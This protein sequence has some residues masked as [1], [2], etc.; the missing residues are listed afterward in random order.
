MNM[1]SLSIKFK[2][3]F[4][5][6]VIKIIPLLFLSYIAY[7][8]VLKLEEYFSSSTKELFIENKEIIANTA[9]KAVGDSIKMLDKKSQIS[10]EKLS[11]ELSNN[12]ANFLYE[13]DKD[14]LFLSTLNL[15]QNVLQNFYNSK[16]RDIIVHGNYFYD[17]ET[18]TWKNRNILD[19]ANRDMIQASL[20][21]NEKEFNF[22][23]PVQ[24]KKQSIPIY[25]EVVYFDLN[26]EE[27]FKV[28]SIDNSLKNISIKK[29]T[30]INSENYFSELA[31]LKKGDIY[32]SDVIGEYVGSKVIGPFTKEKTQKIGIEFEPEKY[33]Y[34]G[35]ENPVGKEFEAIVRFITPYYENNQKVGY[36]SLALDHKHI[37][38][39]TD[40]FDPTGKDS[41]QDISDASSGNYA[42]MWDYEGKN[43]SHAR[44][45]FI[46]GYDKNTGQLAKPWLSEDVSKDFKLSN[47]DINTFL[48]AYPTFKEQNIEKK[49]DLSQIKEGLLGLDCRYLNSA[50]QCQGWMQITENGGYGSFMILWSGVSK[51][52]TGATIPYYT[53]KYNN[54]KRGFGFVT[55][56][57]NVDEFHAA[58]N[59]TKENIDKLLL[60][61]TQTMSESLDKNKNQIDKF[62]FS[63]LNELSI[64]TLVMVVLIV[65]IALLM[66]NYISKKIKNLLLGTENFTKNNLDYRIKVS[67]ND[68]VGRLEMSF[69]N[70]AEQ[71][72][73]LVKEEKDLNETLEERV[74]DEIIKQRTQ[75]QI[76]IQQSK[77][78]SM[79]EMIGNIAHQWRQPLNALG[80]VLQNI[81]FSYEMDELN[82]EFMNKSINKANTLTKAMSKTIDD[83]RNFFRPNKQKEKFILSNN[84]NDTLYLIES[85]L[86]HYQ[87]ELVK[88]INLDSVLLYGFPNEFSQV[89]LNIV[90]NAKDAIIEQKIEMP[91]IE[92]NSYIKEEY[93]YLEIKDNAGGIPL[94]IIDK[95]FE[96]Y[97]TTKEEGK[98]TGIGLYMSKTII[99]NNMEGKIFV[100]NVDKGACFTIIMPI[101]KID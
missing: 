77:L 95:I 76:L 51:L 93:S 2:L 18:N 80:L 71:I 46:V 25:K 40:T 26:G 75:E 92:I 96:P 54:S 29:N 4:L 82:D 56:G 83:F 53:G 14:I 6:I 1:N 84:I 85:T 99:E 78:A 79:G 12:V 68:E 88:N 11:N 36:V 45:Y 43:I 42:F 98:G 21:D 17:F 20:K 35:K 100:N 31:N 3:L 60:T 63:L 47:Q 19:R 66:S 34:A 86:E 58:A 16:T 55:I 69:N 15:N 9:E 37:M 52:T 33:A 48:K 49:Q 61:Q 89:L 24:F 59:E 5:F 22:I 41:K 62:I 7:N 74:K 30:Y 38:Q 81:K 28:S 97:F 32:V 57:A 72:Q 64:V 8:G 70:M 73:K 87:I 13:R 65:V 50:P 101:A 90:N 94:E 91:K 67:S 27:K 39:F 23:D 44:D 10:L